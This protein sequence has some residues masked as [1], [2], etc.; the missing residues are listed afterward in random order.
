[1]YVLIS[2]CGFHFLYLGESFTKR[3]IFQGLFL[4]EYVVNCF[5]FSQVYYLF[6]GF[7]HNFIYLNWILELKT[8]KIQTFNLI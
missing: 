1:M 2:L 6:E 4:H 3:T 5:R 7:V 8:Y